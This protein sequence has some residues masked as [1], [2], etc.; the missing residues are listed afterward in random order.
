[1]LGQCSAED[2]AGLTVEYL[3]DGKELL[4]RLLR[5]GTALPRMPTKPPKVHCASSE[6]EKG[7]HDTE[8]DETSDDSRAVSDDEASL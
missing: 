8:D 4:D 7:V 6:D 1:V 5:H 2:K 3:S